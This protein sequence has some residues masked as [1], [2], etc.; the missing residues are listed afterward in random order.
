M[1]WHIVSGD[2][3]FQVDAPTVDKAFVVALQNL[4]LEQFG[5]FLCGFEHGVDPNGRNTWWGLTENYLEDA[6]YEKIGEHKWRLKVGKPMAGITVR[7]RVATLVKLD[8]NPKQWA[9][10]IAEARSRNSSV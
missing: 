7:R 10:V 1:K 6:G 3:R 4:P 9:A 2:V 5:I 8:R